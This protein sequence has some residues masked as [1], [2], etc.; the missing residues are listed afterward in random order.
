MLVPQRRAIWFIR[1]IGNQ[2]LSNLRD[3]NLIKPRLRNLQHVRSSEMPIN[4]AAFTISAYALHLI[5]SCA[6]P[7]IANE[8]RPLLL[9]NWRVDALRSPAAS[10][11]FHTAGGLRSWPYSLVDL[12]I[13]RRSYRQLQSCNCSVYA[14][15]LVSAGTKKSLTRFVSLFLFD[16]CLNKV[17]T[18]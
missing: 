4:R 13:L 7:W 12:S 10:F 2:P 14:E 9:V 5:A 11:Y 6:L 17:E 15:C 8:R 18:G 16:I 3:D 1:L